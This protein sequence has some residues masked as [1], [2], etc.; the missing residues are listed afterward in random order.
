MK[1][2]VSLFASV[3]LL[4]SCRQ[5]V[6]TPDGMALALGSPESEGMAPERLNRISR[7]LDQAVSENQIPGGVALIAR[8]GKVVY[9]RAFGLSD[10]QND[11]PFEKDAIFRIASQSKA[12]TATAV[13]ML[14]EEG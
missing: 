13:M 7:M 5:P 9:H 6:E 8:N 14:W 10:V 4:G 11:R 3:V 2:L 12:I 1:Y